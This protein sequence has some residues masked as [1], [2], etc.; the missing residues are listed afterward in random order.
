MNPVRLLISLLACAMATLTHAQEQPLEIYIDA[1]YSVS[2]VGAETIE[3]GLRTA[4]SNVGYRV[5]GHDIVI[6]AYDHRANTKRSQKTFER[7]LQSDNALAIIGGMHSPPYITHRDMIN[8]ERVLLLLPWA[9]AAPVTR[10]APGDENWVFRLSVDD[11]YAGRF[12]VDQAVKRGG[13]ARISLLLLESGWGRAGYKNLSAA[14]KDN[15]MASVATEFF[16]TNLGSATALT[17]AEKVVQARSD[18][19]ILLSSW[20]NGATVVNALRERDA[21]VRVFSHWGIMGGDFAGAVPHEVRDALS[22]RVLQTCG[23]RREVEG[24]EVLSV[25]LQNAAFEGSA[26]A[27]VR[28][29]T[30]FV[31]GYDLAK[32]LIAAIEQAARDPRWSGSI[33]DRRLALHTALE[34]LEAPVPGI[35]KT[36][37]APFRAFTPQDRDAHEALGF[38]DLCVARFRTD[39]LLEDGS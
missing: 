10:P 14:L 25:A 33:T 23:L 34:A 38:D 5:A 8:Q 2:P 9:A 15:R 21:S 32:V 12:L 29:P 6:K 4:L 3:L 36:Y 28:A 26:L 39:G 13:C 16:P 24:S 17:I 35:L 22:V 37:K 7:Y 31:H 1:D 19:V 27:E 18:C 11:S 20:H 30:G